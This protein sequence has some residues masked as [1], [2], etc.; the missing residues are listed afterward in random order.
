MKTLFDYKTKKLRKKGSITFIDLFAGIGGFHKAMEV[1]DG[2]CIFASEID[3]NC[4]EVYYANFNIFPDGDITTISEEKIP[5]HDILFAG[6]P[7]QPFSKGGSRKGFEDTRGTLFFDIIRILK[8]HKPKYFLLENVP[9]LI[10][11]D[12]GNTYG[13]ITKTLQ[14]LGYSIPKEPLVLSPHQFGVPVLRKRIYIPGILKTDDDFT[15]KFDKLYETKYSGKYDVNSILQKK[16]DDELKISMYE[17][18]VI[19]M[20]DDFYKIIDIDVV[21]F[22]VWSNYFKTRI[23]DISKD[24][25]KWKR[26]FII[27]NIEL[28]Q[29]NKKDINKWLK[30]YNNLSWVRDT[31]KKFEWQAGKS[32]SSLLDALIQFRPSGVRAKRPNYFSTL[33][34]MNHNQI[35][36]SRMRRAHPEELKCLQSFDK[37]FKIHPDKNIALRQLGNSVNVQV[38]KNILKIMFNQ[39]D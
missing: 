15:N 38:V 39:K 9:N 23:K 26:D 10:T 5:A 8:F 24:T 7:C 27:K 34:A 17:K 33:V 6:F 29:R 13:V 11:H 16:F 20:W 14:D 28:Y 2:E 12:K 22:P 3:R 18:K 21:G 36:G 37:N 31:H 30:E 4:Q 1:Y 35:V 19:R 32:I 25:P